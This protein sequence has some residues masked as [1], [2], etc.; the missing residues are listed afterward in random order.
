[1]IFL[2]ACFTLSEAMSSSATRRI[3][4]LKKYFSSKRPCGVCTYL[5]VVTRRDG[6]LVHADRFGDVAEDHRLQE[7]DALLEELALLLDD[8]LGDA[9]DRL[10]TLLD[11]AN[12][13]LRV[14]EL[15]ADEL[16]GVRILEELLRERLVDVE[17]L[18]AAVV[19]GD[20]PLLFVA[21]R[22]RRRA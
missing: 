9:D 3:D 10:A 17:A 18:H 4:E 12:E 21:A 22:R 15:L 11:R 7:A 16:L 14:A 2:I 8:A 6:R 13:P 1:M 19:V 20:G 5:F